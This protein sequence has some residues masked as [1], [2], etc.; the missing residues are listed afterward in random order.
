MCGICGF[1]PSDQVPDGVIQAMTGALVHRGPDEEGYHTD[2]RVS[3][4]HRRLSIIDL[5]GSRQPLYNEDG[6][7]V[8]VFNG[9]IYNFAA[10]RKELLDLGHVFVTDGDGEVLVH[11]YEQYGPDMLSKIAGMFAFA[12]YDRKNESL[13]LARDHMG[14]KPLYYYWDG[15]TLVFGSELKALLPHPAVKRQVDLNA[16]G[17]FLQCQYIPSPLTIYRQV[18]KLPAGCCLTFSKDRAE[19]RPYWRPDY[20]EKL[21][22]SE[23]EAVRLMEDELKRSVR[24]M[25]ISDV[26]LGAFISGG[27]DSGLIAALMAD[28]LGRPPETFN[29][30]FKNTRGAKSEHLEAERAARAVGSRHHSLM[31]D[32]ADVLDSFDSWLDVFDEPFADAAALP[33]FLLSKLTRRHVTVV[34]TGEGA[35]EIFAGYGNYPKRVKDEALTSVLGAPGSP[36]PF[37]ISLLPAVLRKDR[38][39]SAVARPR[40]ERYVTIPSLIHEAQRR[41]FFTEKFFRSLT[42]RLPE[43]AAEFFEECNS[44]YY[45]DR[46]MYVDARLWLPDDLL[47]KV[48]RATMAYS[49][50]ARVPYL[51]H[52]VVEL[53]ARLKPDLKL[54]Q[55]TS[56]Y[57]LKKIAD[58]YL[59]SDIVHRGKQGFVMPVKEWLQ[60]ELRGELETHLSKQ[61]LLG[62]NLLKAGPVRRL[63]QDHFT[64]R[65]NNS[66][67]L[68]ALLVLELWFK[69]YEP[70]FEL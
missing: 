25:L 13:F 9:E 54:N 62:R 28:G 49:L 22:L 58:K 60:H 51:D 56:K 36:L 53:A 23:D 26:P 11:A 52:R 65:K 61:G 69:R 47:T 37:L 64:D 15:P 50:E 35:D 24:S 29:L 4:G 40:P 57:I 6:S 10:L 3:L 42:R 39:L 44:E 68:W 1:T 32:E 20:R 12:L 55:N 48:D 2:G 19:V 46:I 7:L 18:K 17:L 34:L 41:S 5:A 45:L 67:K 38:L 66:F 63:L 59:P 31:I 27:V 21:D 30:G 33:T 70:D 16:L 14:V 43:F 8:L